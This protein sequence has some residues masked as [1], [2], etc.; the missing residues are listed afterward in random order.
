MN[1]LRLIGLTLAASLMLAAPA[2]AV[3]PTAA[4]FGM[5]VDAM[6]YRLVP[7]AVA[8]Y[9]AAEVT[10]FDMCPASALVE[11]LRNTVHLPLP[12]VSVSGQPRLSPSGCLSIAS[13]PPI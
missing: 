2:L 4:P 10:A 3:A 9:H 7:P 1:Y 6:D 8:A 12:A 11:P 13:R 5:T